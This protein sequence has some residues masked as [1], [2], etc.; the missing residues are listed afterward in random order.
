MKKF[1][2]I[3]LALMLALTMQAAVVPALPAAQT[4]AA[5]RKGLVKSGKKYYYYKKGAKIKK[6]WKTVSVKGVKYR[7]YFGKNGAAYRAKNLYLNAYNVKLFKIGK[8]KYGFDN[9]SHVVAPG[10]YVDGSS[11]IYVF[12]KKGVY[13]NK[14]TKALRAALPKGKISTDMYSRV[15]AKLGRPKK[16]TEA[17]SCNG[18]NATDPFTDLSLV[19]SHFEVQL[20]RN[21]R[22]KEYKLNNYFSI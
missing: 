17:N 2:K 6:K 15:I 5:S 3:C 20:V 13:S 22:T 19:Y 18:W 10:I 11:K 9:Y 14:K 7:F 16:V 4:W 8:K 12:G 1:R 21:D